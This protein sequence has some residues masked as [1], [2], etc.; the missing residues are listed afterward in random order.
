MYKRLTCFD[1]DATLFHTPD[2]STGKRIWQQVMGFPYPH[3]GWWGKAETLDPD[4]FNIPPNQF[5]LSKYHEEISDPENYVILATGRL[6]KVP[7]MRKNIDRILEEN[8]IKFNEVHLCWGGGTYNFK[9]RLFEDTIKK[10]K[11]KNFTMYDDR[12]EHIVEFKRWA[13]GQRA[14]I[15]IFD[16]VNKRETI[17]KNI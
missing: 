12:H 6:S 14:D 13:V 5:V 8:N 3:Q 10:L 9:T 11:V 4:V 15:K 2:E 17:I 7:N 16:V 1:F